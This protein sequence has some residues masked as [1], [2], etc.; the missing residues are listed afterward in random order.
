LPGNSKAFSASNAA[1][2]RRKNSISA[3]Y[4]LRATRQHFCRWALARP[5][6]CEAAF[7]AEA[8]AGAAGRRTTIYLA[9]KARSAVLTSGGEA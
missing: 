6:F 8:S 9:D 3:L 4:A 5:E 2:I 7:R 1:K